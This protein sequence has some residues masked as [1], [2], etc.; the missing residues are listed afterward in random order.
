MNGRRT[1]HFIGIGGVGMAALAVLLKIRGCAVSGCD[2]S[3][4]TAS[5]Q[6]LCHKFHLWSM[7][8]QHFTR[9]QSIDH[10]QMSFA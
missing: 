2:L 6:L 7:Q 8:T 1:V 10:T 9:G 5:R 3:R 4:T